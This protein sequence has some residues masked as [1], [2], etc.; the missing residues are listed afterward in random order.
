MVA[1]WANLAG[2]LLRLGQLSNFAQSD[3]VLKFAAI[4][5]MKFEPSY[6]EI[7]EIS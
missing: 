5:V 2:R 6:D 3:P 7:T 1:T 4:L